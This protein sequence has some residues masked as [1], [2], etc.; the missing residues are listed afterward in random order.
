MPYPSF[1]WQEI[2]PRQVSLINWHLVVIY[3]KEHSRYYL[4]DSSF[5]LISTPQ[6]ISH[7]YICLECSGAILAHCK[8]RLLGSPSQVAGI[9]DTCHC[10]WLMFLHF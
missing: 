7:I 9:T 8:L 2:L 4:L 5:F 6:M 10:A 1:Q 3:I